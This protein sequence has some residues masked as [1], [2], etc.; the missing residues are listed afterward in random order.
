MSRESPHRVF[1]IEIIVIKDNIPHYEPIDP[2][3]HYKCVSSA[4]M[5]EGGDGFH[6][7][8]KYMKNHR[9]QANTFF[10]YKK[11]YIHILLNT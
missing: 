4:Y 11:I 3:K 10:E 9:F 2:N 5:T 8:P 7:I 1:S 6:M